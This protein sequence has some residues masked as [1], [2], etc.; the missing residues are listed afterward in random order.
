MLLLVSVLMV[1]CGSGVNNDFVEEYN[2][3]AKK[4]DAKKLNKDDFSKVEKEENMSWQTLFES[5]H[6]DLSARLKDD[7]SVSGYQLSIKDLQK[8]VSKEGMAYDAALTLSDT[9]GI[10]IQ[11][12]NENIVELILDRD[13]EYKDGDYEIK[14]FSLD[15]NKTSATINIDKQ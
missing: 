12:M 2:K 9:L 15:L 3:N 8:F 4:Y 7:K 14:I 10:S 5:Q 1:G 6:F 13:S 11:K